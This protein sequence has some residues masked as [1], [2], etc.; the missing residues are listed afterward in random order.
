LSGISS[1]QSN[2]AVATVLNAYA[3]FPTIFLTGE[4]KLSE[5]AVIIRDAS[6]PPT[7]QTKCTVTNAN[8]L[9]SSLGG[10]ALI[11]GYSS[12]TNSLDKSMKTKSPDAKFTAV[13]P[14]DMS[15]FTVTFSV[16]MTPMAS[17]T[18]KLRKVLFTADRLSHSADLAYDTTAGPG[19]SELNK[20]NALG[21]EF[22]AT[23]GEL[24]RAM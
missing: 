11:M 16:H 15:T 7:S 4:S 18:L 14:S 12:L 6:N 1:I 23:P 9:G 20:Y 5:N 21:T 24:S 17:A 13:D 3:A 19:D 22:T 10:D 8:Q 2:D